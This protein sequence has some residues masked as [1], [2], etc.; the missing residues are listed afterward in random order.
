[1]EFRSLIDLI[2]FFYQVMEQLIRSTQLSFN[3]K[4]P[5]SISPLSVA[6]TLY[7]R[8]LKRSEGMPRITT[9]TFE[10]I[11]IS[12]VAQAWAFNNFNCSI[13]QSRINRDFLIIRSF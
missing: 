10:M 4:F 9:N 3:Q 5:N 2:I 8:H 6:V 1:M 12:S 13:I 11:Q 7:L